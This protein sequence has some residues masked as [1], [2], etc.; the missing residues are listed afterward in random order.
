[1]KINLARHGFPQAGQY[2][3]ADRLARAYAPQGDFSIYVYGWVDRRGRVKKAA[4]A[5]HRGLP[6]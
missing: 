6:G 1:M 4:V 2:V 5:S 3:R